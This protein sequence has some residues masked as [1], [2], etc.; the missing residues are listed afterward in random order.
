MSSKIN[1]MC[2]INDVSVNQKSA[3]VTLTHKA[4]LCTS[5]AVI[6]PVKNNEI[7]YTKSKDKCSLQI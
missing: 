2:D 1:I 4:T 5:A 3:T 7:Q 6:P